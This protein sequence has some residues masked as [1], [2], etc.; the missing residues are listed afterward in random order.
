M[1]RPAGRR[2]ATWAAGAA[3]VAV[4]VLLA[5][6]RRR[7]GPPQPVTFRHPRRGRLYAWAGLALVVAGVGWCGF[8]SA[9]PEH[10]AD[11][12]LGATAWGVSALLPLLL[13][14]AGAVTVVDAHGVRTRGGLTPRRRRAAW[15][16]VA[17]VTLELA[18]RWDGAVHRVVV[19]R[20]DGRAVPLA[21]PL[22]QT[23]RPASMSALHAAH[24]RV[25]AHWEAGRG[26]GLPTDR[27]RPR[28]NLPTRGSRSFDA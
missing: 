7:G 18:H 5:R 16:E 26:P 20:A 10:A 9:G 17:G 3:L 8:L 13:H 2:T 23:W 28:M 22:G 14:R 6:A 11:R 4:A 27:V 1:T 19:T 12:P 15:P 21:V 24:A 25:V